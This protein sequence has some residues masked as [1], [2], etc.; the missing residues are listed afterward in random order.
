ML[1]QIRVVDCSTDIA[2]PYCT[3][4]LADA[5]ADVVKVES[6]DGDPLR[7]WGSGALFEFL[8]TTKRS[9]LGSPGDPAFL[10]LCAGADVVVDS[11]RPGQLDGAALL[12]RH[13]GLVV[14]SITPFGLDGPWAD[15]AAT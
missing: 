9:V 2:G 12:A 4:L 10:E 6:R 14:T 8:N 3:K 7:S 13:P 15:W 1:E 5:G 11:G